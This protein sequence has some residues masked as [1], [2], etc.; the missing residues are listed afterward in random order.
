MDVEIRDLAVEAMALLSGF[1]EKLPQMASVPGLVRSLVALVTT[2]ANGKPETPRLAGRML[3]MLAM[4]DDRVRS[5]LE[6]LRQPIIHA[7]YQ[8]PVMAEVLWAIFLVGA[9][10]EPAPPVE[11]AA[12]GN[13]TTLAS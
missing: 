2:K 6:T 3:G 10:E 11:E 8:H 9:P 5:E 1:R 12:V 7:A 13:S 4:A